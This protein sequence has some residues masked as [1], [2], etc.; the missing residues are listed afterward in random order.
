MTQSN[1]ASENLVVNRISFT[2]NFLDD[3]T[4][5]SLAKYLFSLGFDS[6]E[7]LEDSNKSAEPI[8]L[9]SEKISTVSFVQIPCSQ[10]IS[11]RFTGPS[12][13]LFYKYIQDN[14]IDWT[15]FSSGILS[16]LDLYYLRRTKV[17]DSVSVASF[18]DQCQKNLTNK[19]HTSITNSKGRLLKIGSR[20]SPLHSRI[21]ESDQSLK[22]EHEMKGKFISPY[23][24]L[25]VDNS[26]DEFEQSLTKHFLTYFARVLP[27]EVCYMDWLVRYLRPISTNYPKPKLTS[28]VFH[29]DYLNS[30][31]TVSFQDRQEIVILLQLIGYV[32]ALPYELD[33]L[34]AVPYRRVTFR[35]KDFFEFQTDGTQAINTY[36]LQKLAKFLKSL[37]KFQRNLLITS[38]T[39]TY[40]QSLVAIPQVEVFKEKKK[41]HNSPW[42]AEIWLVDKLFDYPFPF[43]LPDLFQ[44][45]L[46]KDDF[47]VRF[48]ILQVFSSI[49]IAKEFRIQEFLDTYP[50]KI[51][52]QR[53]TVIKQSFI[54]SVLILNQYKLIEPYYRNLNDEQLY[55]IDKLDRRTLGKGFI[56]Y[57]KLTL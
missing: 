37:T 16:R 57:E 4:K 18:F 15:F 41:D 50:S 19:N 51:S 34:G 20:K 40:F 56:I 39:D 26:I 33:Y 48:R 24:S 28:L 2:F 47:E 49:E 5:K 17:D 42:L 54:N 21:Y 46:S 30:S 31:T 44:K 12:A 45:K 55:S 6:D 9:K 36:Q 52:N 3:L 23:H 29:T 1:F 8:Y 32:Q 38:F 11:V 14:L 7:I 53:I 10:S 13:P 27:L 25:L 35:L 22:F 43:L